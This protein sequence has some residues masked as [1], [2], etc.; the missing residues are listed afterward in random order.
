MGRDFRHWQQ[1]LSCPCGSCW[2]GQPWSSGL[3]R[4][5]QQRWR[6]PPPGSSHCLPMPHL[7]EVT[8]SKDAVLCP[9]DG[10]RAALKES[11]SCSVVSDSLWPHGSVH[12]ILQARI[13]LQGIFPTQ[14]LNPGL[15][16]EDWK[17][18]KTHSIPLGLLGTHLLVCPAFLSL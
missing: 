5:R 13:L 4:L 17:W 3:A 14:G 8:I 18:L 11:E 16:K 6:W 1:R 10:I 7:Q 9:V 2:R 15:L 12:G